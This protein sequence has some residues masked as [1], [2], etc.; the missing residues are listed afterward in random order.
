M[1]IS[2]SNHSFCSLKIGLIQIIIQTRNLRLSIKLE[3]LENIKN[4]LNQDKLVKWL[5]ERLHAL[6]LKQSLL[7]VHMVAWL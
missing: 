7:I 5:K 4:R 1:Y 2:N 3:L 6:T